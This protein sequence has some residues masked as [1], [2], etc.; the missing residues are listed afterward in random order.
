MIK[1]NP[2]REDETKFQIPAFSVTMSQILVT[3]LIVG[4]TVLSFFLYINASYLIDMANI[5]MNSTLNIIEHIL[6][7]LGIGLILI[8][9]W[10]ILI[11]LSIRLLK[12]RNILKSYKN[13]GIKMTAIGVGRDTPSATVI[14]NNLK[15]LGY[16]KTL[17]VS[18]LVEIPNRVLSILSEY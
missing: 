15:Y 14:A 13:L 12:I 2:N 7:L 18:R 1:L 3:I 11:I 9:L 10:S 16:E 6:M 17:A 4:L 8:I 5:A